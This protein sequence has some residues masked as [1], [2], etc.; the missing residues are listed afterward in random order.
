MEFIGP[1]TGAQ[2]YYGKE[3]HLPYRAG[4]EQGARFHDVDPRDV[5]YFAATGLFR[6]IEPPVNTVDNAAPAPT[7]L[8][9]S[10]TWPSP[11]GRQVPA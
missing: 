10:V 8:R 1:Q 5:E 11:K 9:G 4:R 3:S 7:E 6:V 2:T